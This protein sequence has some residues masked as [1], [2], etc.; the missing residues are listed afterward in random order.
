M[1]LNKNF[2]SLDKFIHQALYSPKTGFYMKKNPFGDKGDYITSPLISV[3]FSE[4]LS[5]WTVAFWQNLKCPKNI[6]LIE[7]GAGN[8]QM[9]YD[10]INSFKSFPEFNKSC[11]FYIFETSPYLKKIQKEKLKEFNVIWIKNLNEIKKNYNIFIA[12]EFFD[13][14]PIKQFV[15]KKNKWYEKNIK[16][17]KLQ[18][19]KILDILVNIKKFEKK[20][21]FKISQGQK[22]IEYSP[23]SMKYLKSI[24][25]L[26]KN[27]GGGLLAIDYGYIDPKMKNTLKSIKKHKLTN[28]LDNFSKSDITYDINFKIMEKII[29]KLGLKVNGITNQ[30]N[31]LQ[32]LGILERAEIVSKNLPFS[33]KANIYFRVK[34]LIHENSMG[35]LFKVIF[36]TK[37]NTQFKTGFKN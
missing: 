28:V 23:L 11:K 24:S 3:L 7:L 6:N 34:R 32:K 35:K 37:K 27:N 4:M 15:K 1:S 18:K 19:P 33:K 10:M 2:L 20:I 26:I 21:G 36:A 8:G 14:L 12:N 5:V 31:F 25:E 22:F 9:M 30:K 16:F 29:K 17:S 13:A